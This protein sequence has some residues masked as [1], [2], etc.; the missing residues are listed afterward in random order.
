MK[1]KL[2]Y[3]LAFLAILLPFFQNCSGDKIKSP[4]TV[5]LARTGNSASPDWDKIPD[6]RL[7]AD[8]LGN[9]PVPED[10]EAHFRVAWNEEGILLN[11]ITTDDSFNPDTVTPWNGDA[12]EV[13][14]A[15]SRGSGKI[16]QITVV[17]NDEKTS[18]RY[19]SSRLK[20]ISPVFSG[21]LQVRFSGFSLKESDC[22]LHN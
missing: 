3:I 7:W 11:F 19:D 20:E 9:Y 14:L 10:L 22:Q 6:F 17:P 4:E 21:S 2:L 16:C 5:L 8:P 12:I 15:P 1:N 18:I 13:F